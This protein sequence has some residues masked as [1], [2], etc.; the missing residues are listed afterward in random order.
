MILMKMGKVYIVPHKRRRE[1][2]TDYRLRLALIKSQ[3][4]RL[5]IR[6]TNNNVACQLV[7]YNSKGDKILV[8]VNT[9]NIKKLGWNG[10]CGNLPAAYLTGL[11]CGVEAKKHKINEAILDIGLQSSKRSRL[12]AALKGAVD[13]GLNV[14]HSDEILP[15]EDR[16]RGLHIKAYRNVDVDKN[17]DE[18]K[19]KILGSHSV[20]VSAT[21]KPEKK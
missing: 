16:I 18:V 19:S 12:F 20:T 3:K 5:V 8:S 10:H 15:D 17:F 21:A 13:A 14:P 6:G 11:L 7:N 2:K 4:T 9:S 1:Q